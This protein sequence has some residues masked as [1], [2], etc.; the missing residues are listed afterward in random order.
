[1]PLTRNKRKRKIRSIRK[2]QGRKIKRN[3]RKKK[4]SRKGKRKKMKKRNRRG[5]GLFDDFLK[6]LRKKRRL[7]QP[8]LFKSFHELKNNNKNKFKQNICI[9]CLDT[10][11]TNRTND[12]IKLQCNHIFHTNCIIRLCSY[13]DS[14][15]KINC[16]ICNQITIC[17]NL[18]LNEIANLK[19]Q[20]ALIREEARRKEDEEE[21]KWLLEYEAKLHEQDKKE[22]NDAIHKALNDA[23]N[24]DDNFIDDPYAKPYKDLQEALDTY[25]R[26]ADEVL[27]VEAEAFKKQLYDNRSNWWVKY[28]ERNP[29]ESSDDEDSYY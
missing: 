19:K 4:L 14:D 25:K 11:E 22:A 20:E 23:K 2:T 7:V 9:I 10:L 5:R 6:S 3:Y 26:I 24:I 27:V 15:F 12:V 16:P 1:M 8:V 21:T 18:L 28:Y 13:N 29:V 17:P